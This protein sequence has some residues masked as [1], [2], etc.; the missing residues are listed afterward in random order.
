MGSHERF[1]YENT[2]TRLEGKNKHTLMKLII[3]IVKNVY[4][5]DLEYIKYPEGA[6]EHFEQL[7]GKKTIT[8]SD[9]EAL[10]KLADI[11]FENWSEE[12]QKA[13]DHLKKE[14]EIENH[15]ND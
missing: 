11:K 8:K 4:G 2:R 15:A 13:I 5:N 7:T 14:K 12:W 1:D 9:K 3:T 6:A 10:S